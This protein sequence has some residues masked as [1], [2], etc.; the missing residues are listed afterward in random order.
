MKKFTAE[1]A[2]I[3]TTIIWGGTFVIIKQALTYVSPMVFIASRFMFAL[4]ILLPFLHKILKGFTLTEFKGGLLLGFLYFMGFVTQTA[5]LSYTSATKSG[6]ITG[7]F[8]IFTPIFQF[9]FE[10]KSPSRWNLIG[11]VLVVIGLIFLSSKGTSV[12][13]VFTELGSNFNIGDFLTLLCAVFYSVYIV[14]LDIISKKARF[15]PLVFMQISLTAV[16]GTLFVFLFYAVGIENIKAE[17]NTLVIAALLY[18]AILATIVTTSLQTRF[19]KYVTPTKAGIIFS[20]EPICAAVFAYLL[21]GER[22]G[23]FGIIGGIFIFAGLLVTEILDK[24]APEI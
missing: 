22:I 7:T 4:L 18:T 19:Q 17:F 16:G 9:I 24:R 13:D 12:F 10:R 2:L 6:F 5:G 20:F 21:I 8:V 23:N 3:L 1:G 14:Y 15:M 11:I